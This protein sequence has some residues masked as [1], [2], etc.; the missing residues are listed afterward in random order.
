MVLLAPCRLPRQNPC[1][2]G[3]VYPLRYK[4]DHVTAMK[5]RVHTITLT[6]RLHQRKLQKLICK[7]AVTLKRLEHPNIVP[8]IGFDLD[9]FQFA[10]D[11]R[12]DE[13]DLMEYIQESPNANL[14][15][16]V[17]VRFVVIILRS[18]LSP[19]FRRCKG[20]PI[21]PFP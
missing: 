12:P 5:V 15:A 16:L 21:P 18:V 9:A 13:V 20:A 10:V 1:T 4:D 17:C 8:I 6:I 14:I 19:A 2:V 3:P 7:E 11:R